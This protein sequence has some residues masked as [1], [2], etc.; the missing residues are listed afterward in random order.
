MESYT[1]TLPTISNIYII[2]QKEI[3]LYGENINFTNESINIKSGSLACDPL[4]V[5]PQHILTATYNNDKGT[6][7]IENGELSLGV[8]YEISSEL[9]NVDDY[10]KSICIP[11]IIHISQTS[12]TQIKFIF[13]TPVDAKA[14]CNPYNYWI[15]CDEENPLG[16]AT[17][18]KNDYLTPTSVL[19]PF[20]C[21]IKPA[22][23]FN[24]IFTADFR[25][26]IAPGVKFMLIPSNISYYGMTDYFGP[27]FVENATPSFVGQ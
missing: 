2:N 9:L 8:D 24:T 7:V 27:N 1:S 4:T 18:G 25:V 11:T 15:H 16:I 19:K 5:A 26:P 20:N 13:D 22:D 3:L 10:L 6:F 14:A 21:I 17:L 12:P 23:S